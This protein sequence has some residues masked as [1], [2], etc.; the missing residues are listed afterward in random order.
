MGIREGRADFK[1]K[2]ICL[3]LTS[4]N[5]FTDVPAMGL[6]IIGILY[7]GSFLLESKL[8]IGPCVG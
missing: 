4:L 3:S 2:E 8:F 1:G 6:N 7:A 5:I